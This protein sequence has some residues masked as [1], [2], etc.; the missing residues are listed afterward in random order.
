MKR[1]KSSTLLLR[2]DPSSGMPLFAQ[3]GA[4]I[5]KAVAEGRVGAGDRLPSVRELAK[6]L[7]I[8][9]NTV[10]RAYE[11]LEAEKWI[12]RRQGTGCFVAA[13]SGTGGPPAKDSLESA[14]EQLVMD[15][16]HA[17]STPSALR[18]ALEAALARCRHAQVG[19]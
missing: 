7:G 12:V 19:R 17:G 4:Q 14:F 10:V 3:V 18:A 11:V 13:R 9:P 5:K 15:A 8:N 16:L 1:K 2:V 6:S